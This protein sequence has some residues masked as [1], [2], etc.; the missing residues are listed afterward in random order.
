MT[1]RY[2]SETAWARMLRRLCPE[3]GQKPGEHLNAREFWMPRNCDLTRD[4]V[5]DRIQAY[6]DDLDR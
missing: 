6:H 2:A 5:V 4:G 1:Q 3:C